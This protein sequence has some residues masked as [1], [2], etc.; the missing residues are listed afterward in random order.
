MR[1]SAHDHGALVAARYRIARSPHWRA[2]AKAHLAKHPRCAAC[3]PHA[4][5]VKLQVHHIFPFHWCVRLG[6]PDLE[7]D[8]RNLITLCS[9]GDNHHLLLGHLDDYESADLSVRW[10]ATQTFH[11][12]TRRELHTSARWLELRAARFSSLGSM[13]R[14]HLQRVRARLHSFGSRRIDAVVRLKSV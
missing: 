13:N 1:P 11:G 6:R 3:G 12:F 7:L 10:H 14:A 5:R 8:E 9:G 2:V 4:R